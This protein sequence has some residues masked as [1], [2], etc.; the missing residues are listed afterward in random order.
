M[1]FS[2]SFAYI[3][4]TIKKTNDI[5]DNIIVIK[6]LVVFF[7]LIFPTLILLYIFVKI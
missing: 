7:F 1:F 6:V 3:G 4:L 5:K 2:L